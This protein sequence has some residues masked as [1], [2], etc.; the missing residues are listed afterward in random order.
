MTRVSCFQMLTFSAMKLIELVVNL[1]HS[2]GT[3]TVNRVPTQIHSDTCTSQHKLEQTRVF[4]SMGK[5]RNLEIFL[6]M[7]VV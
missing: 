1:W 7:A 5:G 6:L 3:G 4:E 2:Y